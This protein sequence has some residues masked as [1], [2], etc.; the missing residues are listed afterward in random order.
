MRFARE[1]LF[2]R[3]SVVSE[4]T[5]LKIALRHAG[6]RVTPEQISTAM[7]KQ[8][9]IHRDDDGRAMLTTK[10]ALAEEK[11]MLDFAKKGKGKF[12]PFAAR[13]DAAQ[14][15]LSKAQGKAATGVLTSRDRVT[16]VRG[17]AGTGKTYMM[18][19][20][21]QKIEEQGKK[22][23]AVAPTSDAAHRVLREDG[24]KEAET[25]Q[26]LLVDPK[27]QSR[28]K[29]QVLWVDEA[30][31]LGTR[32]I[33]KLFEV[34]EKQ[35]A[36]V[37]LT[38]DERQ[39]G[40]VERGGPF[41]LLRESGVRSVQLEAIRRQT[42]NYLR[43]V[44]K[45]AGGQRSSAFQ[46]LVDAGWVTES[47]QS[48]S[49]HQIAKEFT[50]AAATGSGKTPLVIAPTHKEKE[51]L[52]TEIRSELY[53]EK[54]LRGKERTFTRLQTLGL[55]EAER[56]QANSYKPGQVIHFH[57]KA[58]GFGAG[59]KTEVLKLDALGN[60]WVKNV[61][62]PSI[63]NHDQADRYDVFEK[64]EL[65]LAKGDKIRITRSGKTNDKLHALRTG[66]KYEVRGFEPR[67]GN[68]ELTNG[69]TIHRDYGH[70]DQGY[71]ETSFASQGKTVDKVIVAQSEQSFGAE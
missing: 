55:T 69:W 47:D 57:K 68:I 61:A 59:E 39:H 53:E 44:E 18:K 30:G 7:G 25:V 20:I 31:L 52:A 48:T 27:L 58:R 12:R 50:R 41:A 64:K 71:V 33:G 23:I 6:H 63:L 45:I 1:H 3:D 43:I 60:V 4:K 21:A 34:A 67:T 24:F 65:Q 36:R 35:K 51:A 40:S 42:G 54:L 28:M 2:E 22:I 56:Q 15:D 19:T 26:R 8:D 32:V 70:I 38:G 14:T 49:H 13:F 9:L 66:G 62:G 17:G 11:A 5:Y 10:Q 29:N 16:V 37:I 46:D